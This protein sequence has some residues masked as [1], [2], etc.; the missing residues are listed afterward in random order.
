MT[1]LEL[2]KELIS[3]IEPKTEMDSDIKKAAVAL[4]AKESPEPKKKPKTGGRKKLNIDWGKAKAC[5]DAGWSYA[6]I[7]DE[8]GCSEQTV[9]THLS[10]E[11]MQ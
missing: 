3:M 6:K 9:Y 5:R 7:A 8:L 4:L 1:N 10:K 11:A 2:V